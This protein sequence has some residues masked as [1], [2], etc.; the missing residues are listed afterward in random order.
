MGRLVQWSSFAAECALRDGPGACGGTGTGSGGVD[1]GGFAAGGVTGDAA[2][3]GA[4][5]LWGKG[6][7]RG[8]C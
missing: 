8:V 4:G 2:E 1:G 5:V 6:T 7:W 3:G